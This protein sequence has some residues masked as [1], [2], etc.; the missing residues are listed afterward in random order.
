MPLC[1]E[2]WP[3]HSFKSAL[4]LFFKHQTQWVSDWEIQKSASITLCE[5]PVTWIFKVQWEDF[6][7]ALALIRS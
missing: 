1:A 2:Q 4:G 7:F 3:L 6:Y 5:L